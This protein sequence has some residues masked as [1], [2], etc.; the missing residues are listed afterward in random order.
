[1]ARFEVCGHIWADISETGYGVS[2]LNDC[3]YG[4]NVYDNAMKISLLKS[5]KYPD[6]QADIGIHQFTYAL[7]PHGGNVLEG[8]TMEEAGDLNAPSVVF[9]GRKC[10]GTTVV[11]VSSPAVQIDAVKKAQKEDCL[12]V[13]VHECRGSTVKFAFSSYFAIGKMVRCNLLEESIDECAAEENITLRPFEI[14]TVKIYPD[15]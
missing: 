1:M 15:I 11:E 2:L 9:A 6:R 7:L 13:R 3:K 12:V 10:T 14:C 5:A 4:Y 8:K